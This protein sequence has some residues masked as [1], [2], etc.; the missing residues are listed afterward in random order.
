VSAPR[1]CDGPTHARQ[2][3]EMLRRDIKALCRATSARRGAVDVSST[4]A[5]WAAER[6]GWLLRAMELTALSDGGAT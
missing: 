1:Q 4:L 3:A 6:D 5:A 2:I